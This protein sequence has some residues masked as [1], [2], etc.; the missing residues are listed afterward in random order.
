MTGQVLE[1]EPQ[2]VKPQFVLDDAEQAE[3]RRFLWP[4]WINPNEFPAIIRLMHRL[5]RAQK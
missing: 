2:Q 5:E 4:Q 1:R 3:L